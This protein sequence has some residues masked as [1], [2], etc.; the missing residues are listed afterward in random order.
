MKIKRPVVLCNVLCISI[1]LLGHMSH[2]HLVVM[3]CVTILMSLA[4]LELTKRFKW[5]GF[6]SMMIFIGIFILRVTYLEINADKSVSLGTVDLQGRVTSIQKETKDGKLTLELLS[7]GGKTGRVYLRILSDKKIHIGDQIAFSGKYAPLKEDRNPGGF[8]EQRYYQTKGWSYKYY[9]KSYKVIHHRFNLKEQLYK[10]KKV[11]VSKLDS[12][13]AEEESYIMKRMLLGGNYEEGKGIKELYQKGGVLHILAISGLHIML[14]GACCYQL[15][16]RIWSKSIAYIITIVFLVFYGALTGMAVSTTR[17]IIMFAILFLSQ[18]MGRK[19]D[20]A[21]TLSIASLILLCIN[22]YSL[23][24]VGFLLSFGAVSSL[25]FITPLIT[26]KRAKGLGTYLTASLAAFLGTWPLVAYFFHTMALAGLLLNVLI[27]PL[28]P[29]ILLFGMAGMILSCAHIML[30]K[31]VIAINYYLLVLIKKLLSFV[32]ALPGAFFSIGQP[33]WPFIILYYTL[34]ALIVYYVKTRKMGVLRCMLGS[35]IIG[36]IM[37][38]SIPSQNTRVTFLDVG[39]GDGS[40]IEIGG[41]TAVI[42]TGVTGEEV[43]DYLK[44]RG[45]NKIDEFYVSHS[46]QDHMGGLLFIMEAVK[47]NHIYV[48]DS[49]TQLNKLLAQVE[50]EAKLKG[51]PISRITQGM[52]HSIP[53]GMIR[54]IGP[55]TDV[56][57]ESANESSL[58]LE[59]HIEDKKILFT[60]DI[61]D[62]G[63]SES[64]SLVTDVDI[65]KIPHH[66]SKTS[67][68]DA[69][70]LKTRAEYGIISSGIRNR[71]GH[72]HKEVVKRLEKYLIKQYN[73]A[74]DGAIICYID[75]SGIKVKKWLRD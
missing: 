20:G 2:G 23:Y 34:L 73:T 4:M 21:T 64:L 19:G 3:S 65:I 56:S 74:T 10:V 47:I 5:Q 38:I 69:F 58:V 36:L 72:P 22:P 15:L 59:V 55:K 62:D 40:V 24:D 42:D 51:I 27:V 52:Y 45:I 14:I 16:K 60:G 61:E 18:V 28:V 25:M 71:Y 46:D 13:L 53:K 37:I 67:S 32:V 50:K 9:A 41:Y 44:Y 43:V 1:I 12:L 68:G 70:L 66:G 30:G 48:S 8:N 33:P 54:C 17:A 7:S 75:S 63:E 35:I 29:L 11:L 39:Q 31:F 49:K 57:Y 26:F 6:F